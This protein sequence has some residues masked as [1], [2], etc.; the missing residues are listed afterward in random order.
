M[1][2]VGATAR[3]EDVARA[4][5]ALSRAMKVLASY[6]NP[7]RRFA[8]LVQ[9]AHKELRALLQRQGEISLAVEASALV[10]EGETVLSDR[11]R[12]LSL[13]FRLHRDGVRRLT[14]RPGLSCDE[15]AVFARI[16]MPESLGGSDAGREDALLE[17]WKADL[18]GIGY[19]AAA[20]HELARNEA[21]AA[22]LQRATDAARAALRA[23]GQ[24]PSEDAE[25]DRPPLVDADERSVLDP[26][27]AGRQLE[28]SAA[29][30]LRLF[31]RHIAGGDSEPLIETMGKLIDEMLRHGDVGA[32]SLTLDRLSRD[33]SSELTQMVALSLGERWR[34]GHLAALCESNIDLFIFSLPVYLG[35]LPPEAGVPLVEALSDTEAKGVREAFAAAAMQRLHSCRAAIE[36]AM[37]NGPPGIPQALLDAASVLSSSER[38][39]LAAMALRHRDVGVQVE[40]VRAVS[41]WDPRR[42]LELFPPLLGHQE[43]AVR[44]VAAEALAA[45]PT[46]QASAALLSRMRTLDFAV[47]QRGEREVFFEALGKQR[48]SSGF[49]FLS[50]KLTVPSRNPL[51][52]ARAIEEQLLAVRG[53]VAEGTERACRVLEHAGSPDSH[54]PPAVIAASRAA[55]AH[56]RTGTPPDPEAT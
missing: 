40:A 26:D 39:A 49:A 52:K 46:E 28:R 2:F 55:A 5:D 7:R 11:G 20:V 38:A 12:E 25:K 37:E 19:E 35:L 36:Q 47:E 43:S 18:E 45:V 41:A 3:A 30:I 10:Y 8:E 4:F 42:S 29:V 33:T 54:Y 23:R 48:T 34:L 17:L 16:A 15:L 51:Q 50:E 56:L 9:P 6:R 27:G 21:D 13:T 32:L 31:E 44:M 24:A 14:F 1:M 22:E 53:L